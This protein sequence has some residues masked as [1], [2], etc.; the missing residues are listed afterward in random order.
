MITRSCG[1]GARATVALADDIVLIGEATTGEEAQQLCREL[2][3]DILLLDLHMPGPP[4]SA[5]AHVVAYR[6]ACPATRVLVLT[7]HDEDAYVRALLAAGVG[8]YVLKDEV[9]RRRFCTRSVA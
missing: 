4:P 7:A 1:R 8:G 3:P 9:R 5:A 6:A 2:T